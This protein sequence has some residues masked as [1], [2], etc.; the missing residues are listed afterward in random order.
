LRGLAK[1]KL[2]EKHLGNIYGGKLVLAPSDF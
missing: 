2:L 1:I